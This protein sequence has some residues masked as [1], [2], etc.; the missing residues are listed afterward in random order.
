MARLASLMAGL[1]VNPCITDFLFKN[2]TK[3]NPE[4]TV[5]PTKIEPLIKCRTADALILFDLDLSS[6]ISL[7]S[8]V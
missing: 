5:P 8:N 1:V 7:A 3:D 2:V 4:A 6:E